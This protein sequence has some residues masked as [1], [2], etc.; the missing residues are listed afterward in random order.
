M[1]LR[2]LNA[3]SY[4]SNVYKSRVPGFQ[5]SSCNESDHRL[6]HSYMDQVVCSVQVAAD[7]WLAR[8][9]D[10]PPKYRSRVILLHEL[11]IS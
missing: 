8:G 6:V 1:A 9:K 2:H 11:H 4:D 7:Y 10:V 5:C 3:V